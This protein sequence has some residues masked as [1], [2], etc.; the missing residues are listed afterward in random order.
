MKRALKITG[1]SLGCLLGLAIIAVVVAY[2][3]ITSP[4]RLTKLVQKNV[5]K[6]VDFDL[7]LQ[8][9]KLTLKTFPDIGLEI[10]GVTIMSPMEGAP[11]DTLAHVAKLTV[12]ADAKRY[13][14]G[15]DIVVKQ[16]ILDNVYVN[17]FT[18]AEG[19][20]N[21]DI[22]SSESSDTTS[23]SFES[24]L[25]LQEVKIN[26]AKVLYNDQRSKLSADARGLDLDVKGTLD[27]KEKNVNAVL[28]LGAK[29]LRVNT[30]AVKGD[31][32]QLSL[33]FDGKIEN[34]NKVDGKLNL[35]STDASLNAGY[36]VLKHDKVSLNLPVALV[37][38]PLEGQ[39]NEALIGLNDYKITLGGL[40]RS[41]RNDA[42][43]GIALDMNFNTNTLDIEDVMGK[44]PEN[45]RKSLADMGIK[46]KATLSDGH[47]NGMVS[48]SL[49]P[50]ITAQVNAN[51]AELRLPQLPYPFTNANLS[52]KVHIDL[53]DSINVNDIQLSAMMN[54]SKIDV[55]GDVTD[56]TDDM[57]FD[58]N[59]KSNLVLKDLKK[60]LPKTMSLGGKGDLKM[61]L[62]CKLNELLSAIDKMSFDKLHANA[63]LALRD[64]A[65][66]MDTIHAQTPKMNLALTLPASRKAKGRKGAY[67]ELTSQT[68]DASVGKAIQA[69]LKDMSLKGNA[70]QFKQGIEQ[71]LAQADLSFSDLKFGMDTIQCH[72]VAPSISLE[73]SPKKKQGLNAKV[74]FKSNALNAALGQTYKLNTQALA[75]V[76]SARH[77]KS[78]S[79]FFNQW[80]PD[81]DFTLTKAEIDIQGMDE[82][83]YIPSIEF[84]LNDSEL[85]FKKGGIR[86]GRS[87]LNMKGMVTGI[88]PWMEN[89]DNLMMAE[90]TVNSNCLDV[91]EI[92]ELT[93][94]LGVKADSTVV[95]TPEEK[96]DNPFMV[97]EG[98]DFTFNIHS[99]KAIYRNF[100]FNQVEGEATI[101][102]GTLMLQEIGFTNEA[103]RMQLTA[104]YQSPRK[105]NLFLGLDFHLLDVQIHDLLHMIPEID[106]IV[107]MLKTFDG[108]AEFHI[109]AQTNLKSNYDLKKSTLRASA[110]I[111]GANLR[112]KDITTYEK[113]TDMLKVSTNGEYKID[114]IDIQLT[115]F[116]DEVDLWPF[117]IAIGKYKAT[118][119]GHYNWNTV[120]EYHISVTDSP[121]PTRLGLKISGPLNNLSYKLES[122]KY[123][124]LYRPERRNDTEEMVMQLKKKIADRLKATVRE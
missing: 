58:V 74:G 84:E 124:H 36:E 116:K 94:G 68:L 89:H 52:S 6:F 54:R 83:I 104:M 12:G 77:D 72:A 13:L 101:K 75:M 102:D 95:E 18:N 8:Q 44:L 87:D 51:D 81:A 60:L 1:I 31:L 91:N 32:R 45:V 38:D 78:K 82:K 98:F 107:P 59:L 118:V 86:I 39:V 70:D 47:V 119:D 22:F 120:G 79:D 35:G 100:E 96:E 23:S 114:S 19:K 62:R 2:S 20:S 49:M 34:F 25:D 71:M 50:V 92:M 26:N 28:D 106:T 65:F 5:P 33:G 48:D 80:N 53:N 110:D 105:N 56:L 55:T 115:A 99:N 43:D 40:L 97:P 41:A 15:K 85:D 42:N 117:Q 103:A 88:K 73:T 123:P 64:L 93:S 66:D 76:A 37:I 30:E 16:C 112:V 111:E 3:T 7:Q 9:A 67:I 61:N 90:L 57:A 46:G 113:I 109:A 63:T 122:C 21:L 29:Q 27:L 4:K 24:L 108:A 11:S 10:D 14:N 69:G 17:L 121:L